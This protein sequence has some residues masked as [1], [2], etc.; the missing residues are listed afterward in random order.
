MQRTTATWTCVSLLSIGNTRGGTAVVLLVK[1][2]RSAQRQGSCC[3]KVLRKCFDSPSTSEAHLNAGPVGVEVEVGSPAGFL[4]LD[5]NQIWHITVE[6]RWATVLLSAQVA[7]LTAKLP[8][9]SSR[10]NTGPIKRA[11]VFI[12]F[13]YAEAISSSQPVF[14]PC[15]WCCCWA[16]Q[17]AENCPAG[18][19]EHLTVKG[20]RVM[21]WT[22]TV[23]SEN[24]KGPWETLLPN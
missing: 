22:F 8:K 21:T 7:A 16:R 1:T 24:H 6:D 15:C 11:I 19:F 4:C 14:S 3:R 23:P 17:E 5:S 13:F 9:G 2:R 20:T 18:N 10:K 12:L